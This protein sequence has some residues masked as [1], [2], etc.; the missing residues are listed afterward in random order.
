MA[1]PAR[2]AATKLIVVVRAADAADYD[3]VLDV[4]VGAGIRSVELTLTTPGTI[5][6]LPQSVGP[7]RRRRRHRRESA[8]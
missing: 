5:E 8:P 6:R 7:F 4:L 1:I 3:R 2:T